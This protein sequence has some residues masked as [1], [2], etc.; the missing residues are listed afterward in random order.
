MTKKWPEIHEQTKQSDLDIVWD[1][2]DEDEKSD[3][4][5]IVLTFAH[6]NSHS[7]LKQWCKD[8]YNLNKYNDALIYKN[9]IKW[10]KN[11]VYLLYFYNTRLSIS[12]SEQQKRGERI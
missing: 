8:K 2:L 1:T 12:I 7:D 10:S 9:I 3:F 6:N 4:K 5:Y 11:I